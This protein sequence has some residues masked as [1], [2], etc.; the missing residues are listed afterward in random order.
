MGNSA[1]KNAFLVSFL[2]LSKGFKQQYNN[3]LDD[4]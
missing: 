1:F 3:N 4:L 2:E